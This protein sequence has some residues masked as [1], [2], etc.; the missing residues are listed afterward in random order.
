MALLT[1]LRARIAAAPPPVI[2]PQPALPSQPVPTDSRRPPDPLM[3]AGGVGLV[4]GGALLAGTAVAAIEG[5]RVDRDGA[6]AVTRGAGSA[7]LDELRRRGERANEAA[8]GTAIAGALLVTAG[9]ALLIAGRVRRPPIAAA[10][11]IAAPGFV[12]MS[13][14]TRF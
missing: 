5:L 6:R 1:D 4:L 8:V 12:G 13:F 11:P 2:L 9:I 14:G 10:A 3:I 7:E